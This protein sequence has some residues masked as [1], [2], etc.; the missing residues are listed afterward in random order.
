MR[1]KSLFCMQ[2]TKSTWKWD[3]VAC[4]FLVGLLLTSQIALGQV[5]TQDVP[6]KASLQGFDVVSIR[7]SRSTSSESDITPIGNGYNLRNTTIGEMIAIAYDVR[8]DQIE[9]LPS[10]VKSERFDV[11]ARI[12]EPSSSAIESVSWIQRRSFLLAVLKDRFQLQAHL[13]EAI[14]PVYWLR[15]LSKLNKLHKAAYVTSGANGK[16]M[17]TSLL[18]GDIVVTDRF[19]KGNNVPA[20]LLAKNLGILLERDVI[21]DTGYKGLYNISLQWIPYDAP[22]PQ[23]GSFDVRS[24]IFRAIETQ[25]GLKLT[26]GKGPVRT[27]TVD[28][29]ARPSPN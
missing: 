6:S 23:P 18:E 19:L 12:T 9:R 14:R 17:D 24:D 28:N 26:G 16:P 27:V 25:L 3:E 8:Q 7:P 15:P 5:E 1:Y 20:A 2:P 21:D 11:L 13:G 4:V 22:V 10:W 29:L